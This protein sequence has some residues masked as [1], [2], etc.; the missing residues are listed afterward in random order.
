MKK[1]INP[2]NIVEVDI[3]EPYKNSGESWDTT[4]SHKWKLRFVTN[5][6]IDNFPYSFDYEYE[7]KEECE[8]ILL[9]MNLICL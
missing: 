7:T 8:E 1:F 4:P 9:R 3:K 5:T 2:Q 6:V